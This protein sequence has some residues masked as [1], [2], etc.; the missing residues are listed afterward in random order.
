MNKKNILF[1]CLTFIIIFLIF[2]LR[3]GLDVL[4]PTSNN[5]IMS[6]YHDWGQHYLGSVFFYNEEWKFPLGKIDNYNFPAGTT[7]GYT[8]SIP[9]MSIIGKVFYFLFPENFQFLGFWLLLSHL[10]LA[11]FCIKICKLYTSNFLYIFLITLLIS[12]NPVLMYRDMHPALTSHWL[13]VG[14]LYYYLELNKNNFKRSLISQFKLLIASALINPYLLLICLGINFIT[15]IKIYFFDKSIYLKKLFIYIIINISTIIFLWY[16]TG[17]ISFGNNINMEV[18][19]SYGLYSLNLNSFFN[20]EAFSKFLPPLEKISPHQYE[21]FCYLG[22]GFIILL[23]FSVV[24]F[25]Y[26]FKIWKLSFQKYFPIAII[27]ILLLLFAITNTISLNNEVLFKI[28]LPEIIIKIGGIFR[29]SGRFVWLFY[30]FIVFFSFIILLKVKI[31][32][33][34]KT[35]FIFFVFIIQFYDISPLFAKN[36]PKG[37]YKNG[38]LTENKW[39]DL[40]SNFSKIVTYK[41]FENHLKSHMDYQDLCFVALKNKLPITIGYVARESTAINQK[42]ID[43]LN[44]EILNNNFTTKEIFVTTEKYLDVFETSIYFKKLNVRFLDGYFLLYSSDKILKKNFHESK[45]EKDTINKLKQKIKDKF[46]YIELQNPYI[47]DLLIEG[48]IENTFKTE[49]YLELSGWAFLKN[50]ASLKDSVFIL[51]KNENKSYLFKSDYS[52]RPDLINHFKNENLLNSGFKCKAILSELEEG[53]YQVLI[54]LKD[55]NKYVFKNSNNNIITIKK[56]IFPTEI[57]FTYEESENVLLNIE[58]VQSENNKILI[59]GWAALKSEDSYKNKIKLIFKG[60]T[61]YVLDVNYYIREDVTQ[62]FKE[63]TG[64]NYNNSGFYL[65]LKT[66]N[67]PKKGTYRLGVLIIDKQ[68]NIFYRLSDKKIQVK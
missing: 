20:S 2:I 28:S 52:E 21:G 65:D 34:L 35:V 46:K 30:Y 6:A 33:Q 5:W 14:C 11:Y 19:N 43:S 13:F 3:F 9:L 36:L 16:L 18:S 54:G 23:V 10:L 48:N 8:D 37:E 53:N 49:D 58:E 31:K 57:K 63:T 32:K 45:S 7:V 25:L 26:N 1:Y 24:L 61:D 55:N 38:K 68:E 56:D 27:S 42:F 44:L 67:I 4:L 40:T 60:N 62:F 59:K 29:A 22:L 12:F 41:P 39:I 66:K 51:L 15:L 50:N 47:N 64:K 17:M